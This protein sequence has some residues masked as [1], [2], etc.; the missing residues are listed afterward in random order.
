LV[1]E[2]GEIVKKFTDAEMQLTKDALDFIQSQPNSDTVADYL[3]NILTSFQR[4]PFLISSELV[5]ELLEKG[6]EVKLEQ[7]I[8]KPKVEQKPSELSHKK[9]KP[10]AREYEARVKVLKD[11]TGKSYSQGQVGDFL[12]LFKNRF[13]KLSNILRN[14]LE[15][16]NAVPISSLRGMKKGERVSIIGIVMDK[17]QYSTG[18]IF[19]ELEDPTGAL[20]RVIVSAKN[21]RLHE[22]AEHVIV[23]EVIGVVGSI[24]SDGEASLFANEILWPSLP[25]HRERRRAEVPLNAVMISD[26]HV[27]SEQF[28]DKLYEK[29][30][31]WIRGESGTEREREAASRVKYIIIAGD[32]VDGI[33]IYPEQKSE[34]LI[35]DIYRQYDTAAKL[36]S[37]IPDYIQLIIAP[38]NH[39]ATR[40]PEPQPAISHEIAAPLY[41]RGFQMVGNPA[42][43]SLEG[44]YFLA[45]HGRSFDDLIP[46]VPGLSRLYPTKPMIELLNRRHL[47]PIY[48]GRTAISPEPEDLMVI[49]ELPDVFHCGHIHRY[50]IESYR[51]ILVVNSATFQA[52]TQYMRKMGVDPTPGYVPVFN[53]QT[54]EVMVMQFG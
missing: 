47:S 27:G 35:P 29:F 30:L 21:R 20:A 3:F 22:V 44:V 37:E 24:V 28:L 18:T 2:A 6:P 26:L 17:R 5:K 34:L 43:L 16:E 11:I 53:L 8:S 19:L 39:D 40:S 36:L 52:K 9:F 7:Y 15:L 12:K 32:V 54:H 48:G 49:D 51:G 13:E 33:G 45:Y 14:R 50:G 41:E 38:G 25:V 1:L 31:K 10:I 42:L 4:K 23:D 46:A